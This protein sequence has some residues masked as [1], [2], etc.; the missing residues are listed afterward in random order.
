[1]DSETWA[2]VV[3]GQPRGPR[4]PGSE[5]T[6]DSQA[7]P[8]PGGYSMVAMTSRTRSEAARRDPALGEADRGRCGGACGAVEAGACPPPTPGLGEAGLG[9]PGAHL[10]FTRGPACRRTHHLPS[11]GHAHAHSPLP[12]GVSSWVTPPV[13]LDSGALPGSGLLWPWNKRLTAQGLSHPREPAPTP[14]PRWRDA[15]T[16][17]REGQQAVCR[18]RG[19]PVARL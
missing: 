3:T 8:L 19:D 14:T 15:H 2:R 11:G 4:G 6:E 18:R 13:P 1:M 5:P 12:T 10:G 9:H 7:A 16:E 17:A